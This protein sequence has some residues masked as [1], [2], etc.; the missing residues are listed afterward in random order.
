MLR[1]FSINIATWGLLVAS[2]MSL[3]WPLEPVLADTELEVSKFAVEGYEVTG[4][5]PLPDHQTESIVSP[6]TGQAMTLEDL[7]QAT[8]ALE[9]A[10]RDN[11]YAFHRVILP[12]QTLDQG[13]V[14]LKV[15]AFPLV[16][17]EISDNRFHSDEN[18]LR[19]LPG[20]KIG[21]SPH[22][23]TLQR[24][25]AIANLNPS[26]QTQVFFSVEQDTGL[27]ADITLKDQKTQNGLIWLND[28]G[29]EETGDYRTGLAYQNSNLF[30]RDHI[31]NA[32]YSTSPEQPE[33][34][35]QYAVSY[36]L[37]FYRAGGMMNLYAIRSDVD[38]GNIA[39]FFDVAGRGDFLGTDFTYALPNR[40]L[41]KH[42]VVAGLDDKLFD[43]DI[44][45][46]GEPI[47]ID[48]RSRPFSLRHRGNWK[49]DGLTGETYASYN[50]NIESGSDNDDISYALTRAG[51]TPE[52]SA[53]RFGG[54]LKY[55]IG[56]WTFA[57]RLDAQFTDDALI[58]GE[59]FGVGGPGSLRGIDPRQLTGDNGVFM[60]GEF[61]T[62]QLTEKAPKLLMFVEGAW[63]DNNNTL[64]GDIR[65]DTVVSGGLGLRWSWNRRIVFSIDYGYLLDGSAS[66]EAADVREGDGRFHFQILGRI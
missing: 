53:L 47:G 45:F 5:N 31:L 60:S 61:I 10:I 12:A 14:I 46:Q 8:S 27:V 43:N 11:G 6:F 18:V 48:V 32:S 63:L 19:S 9:D 24:S 59:Q 44:D 37:P 39:T 1:Q 7:R 58:P 42:F 20:L 66:Q 51:A 33:D 52:W 57:N 15:L 30:D 56:R 49:K 16:E 3:F 38:S 25:L 62:P 65:N 2:L 55:G 64:P 54:A 17:A 22:T 13:V 4:P 21:E 26:K 34:V 23:L 36:Q 29:S 35:Q 50:V 28:V 41:Y 40:G